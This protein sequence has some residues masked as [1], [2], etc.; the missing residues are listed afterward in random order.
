MPAYRTP[1]GRLVPEAAVSV[2]FARSGG[3]GGQHVNTSSTK[4]R[5]VITLDR[6]NLPVEEQA[7]LRSRFGKEI[8]ATCESERSQLR[9]RVRALN[10]A[11]EKL[12]DALKKMPP[13]TPTRPTRGAVERRLEDKRAASERKRERNRRDWD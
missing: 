6:L 8:V 13:R 5:V 7:E 2:S 1:F 3:P 10:L 9:N 11:L 12:D 4:A